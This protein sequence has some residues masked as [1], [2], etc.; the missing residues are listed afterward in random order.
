VEAHLEEV[1][2]DESEGSNCERED[3][4]NYQGN[5]ELAHLCLLN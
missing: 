3:G 4:N 5:H 2:E 1:P